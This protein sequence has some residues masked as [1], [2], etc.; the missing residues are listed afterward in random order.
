MA[1]V[2]CRESFDVLS[3]CFAV[4]AAIW[5]AG[6]KGIIPIFVSTKMGLSLLGFFKPSWIVLT[7][8]FLQAQNKF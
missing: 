1:L 3:R 8:K 4:F 5:K 7:Q 6:K 2:G